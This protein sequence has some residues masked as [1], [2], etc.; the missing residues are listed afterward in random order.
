MV[1]MMIHIIISYHNGEGKEPDV[2]NTVIDDDN[3]N[4]VVTGVMMLILHQYH[5]N[6]HHATLLCREI[7]LLPLFRL[8]FSV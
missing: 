5:Q 3:N 1:I 8:V 6:R 4:G 2:G 7:V